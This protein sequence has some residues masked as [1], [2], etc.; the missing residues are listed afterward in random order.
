[1]DVHGSSVP[2]SLTHSSSVRVIVRV[3][4]PAAR[5]CED[6]CVDGAALHLVS[7]G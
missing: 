4:G 3:R 1:M 2:F 7:T 6:T 5:W